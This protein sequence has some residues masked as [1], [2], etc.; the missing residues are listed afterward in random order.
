MNRLCGNKG[1]SELV[2]YN[3]ERIRC[4]LQRRWLGSHDVS[5]NE[6]SSSSFCLL[7]EDIERDS[8]PTKIKAVIFN[9]RDL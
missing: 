9:S 6:Y 4:T 1:I 7:I 8:Y 3:H 5:S 2:F